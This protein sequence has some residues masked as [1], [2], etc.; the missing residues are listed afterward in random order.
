MSGFVKLLTGVIDF[1]ANAEGQPVLAAMTALPEILAYRTGQPPASLVA[2]TLIEPQVVPGPWR[3]LVFGYP[4]RL[5][6]TADRTA[7][8]LCVLEQFW[9]HLKWREIY[10]GASTRWRNPRARLLAG[11]RMGGGRG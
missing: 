4:A 11:G 5:D 7:Y 10:A 9:R 1:G 8:T 2:G 3:R 6:K